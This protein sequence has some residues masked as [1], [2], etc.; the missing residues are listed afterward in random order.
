[1]KKLSCKIG[2][3]DLFSYERSITRKYDVSK[4]KFLVTYEKVTRCQRCS[5]VGSST[6]RKVYE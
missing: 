1:M 4:M 5:Y 2:S 3:H 6:Y